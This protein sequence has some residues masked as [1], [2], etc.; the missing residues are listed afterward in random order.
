MFAAINADAAEASR[1]AAAETLEAQCSRVTATYEQALRAL[2]DGDRDQAQG[3][4]PGCLRVGS[5]RV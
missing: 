2:R 4:W 1:D 5:G 3:A